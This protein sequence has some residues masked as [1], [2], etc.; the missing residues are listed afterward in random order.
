MANA[1]ELVRRLSDLIPGPSPNLANPVLRVID[2]GA[3]PTSRPATESDDWADDPAAVA[4]TLIFHPAKGVR[5][6]MAGAD[7]VGLI[8]AV[9]DFGGLVALNPGFPEA[10]LAAEGASPGG[11][12]N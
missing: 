1:N 3:F 9:R 8:Q 12:I 11:P 4:L 5:L 10:L 2:G 7:R 6:R